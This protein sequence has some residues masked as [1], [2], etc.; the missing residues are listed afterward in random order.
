MIA[1]R[2]KF[3]VCTQ[4]TLKVSCLCVCVCGAWTP[5]EMISTNFFHRDANSCNRNQAP[6]SRTPE[7]SHSVT[8]LCGWGREIKLCPLPFLVA[9]VLKRYHRSNTSPKQ[10]SCNVKNAC[11]FYHRHMAMHLRL[12]IPH[13]REGSDIQLVITHMLGLFKA[14][15]ATQCL[16]CTLIRARC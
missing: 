2:I 7:I 12:I 1:S 15:Q 13:A 4:Y 11:C 3:F 5:S 6:L 16:E 10:L 14:K 9:V 8:I